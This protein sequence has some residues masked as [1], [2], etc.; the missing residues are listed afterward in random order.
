MGRRRERLDAG[1]PVW[2]L[3]SGQFLATNWKEKVKGR[4][5]SK[6]I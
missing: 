2:K 1:R 4:E 5:R 3:F 6:M